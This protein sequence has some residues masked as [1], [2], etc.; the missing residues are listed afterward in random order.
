MRPTNTYHFKAEYLDGTIYEQGAD[1]ISVQDPEKNAFYDIFYQ[2]IR[3]LDQLAMF[4]LISPDGLPEF[5]V[6]FIDG[7]FRVGG[8]AYFPYERMKDGKDIVLSNYRLIYRAMRSAETTVKFTHG[9]DQ[10]EVTGAN[11][12]TAGYIVGYQ[13]N[14]QD[15]KNHTYVMRFYT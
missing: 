9:K 4:H 10:G 14:D 13:A 8:V 2:P 15:G 5:S 1:D 11:I 7:H 12:S 3:P 6:S